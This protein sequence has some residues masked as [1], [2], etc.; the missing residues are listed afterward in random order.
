M[1]ATHG[2]LID[3]KV[4]QLAETP[5]TMIANQA[6]LLRC[7]VFN[8]AYMQSAYIVQIERLLSLK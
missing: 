1:N 8:N 2:L 6:S 7:Q 3:N 4:V 5:G